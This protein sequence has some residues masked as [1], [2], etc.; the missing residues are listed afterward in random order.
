[1]RSKPSAIFEATDIAADLIRSRKAKSFTKESRPDTSYISLTSFRAAC[2]AV[3]S[4]NRE[5]VANFELS[6][7]NFESGLFDTN[8][9]YLLEIGD[10]L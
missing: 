9:A 3:K 8:S 4:S 6:T 10:A 2:H 1:M 5:I 7:L